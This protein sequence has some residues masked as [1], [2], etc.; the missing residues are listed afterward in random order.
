MAFFPKELHSTLDPAKKD[1]DGDHEK[2]PLK[3][4]GISIGNKLSRLEQFGEEAEARAAGKQE[5]DNNEKDVLADEDGEDELRDDDLLNEL[6]DEDYE[7]AEED[8]YEFNHFDNGEEDDLGDD[9][10]LEDFGADED[11]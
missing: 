7:D 3:K 10:P 1:D 2:Q 8:D 4:L 5:E 6:Q 9:P 11:I